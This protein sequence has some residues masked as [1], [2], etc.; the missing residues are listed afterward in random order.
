MATVEI[1]QSGRDAVRID[2]VRGAL[3]SS[4]S[5]QNRGDSDNGVFIIKTSADD[6][7]ARETVSE[8]MLKALS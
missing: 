3:D 2:E 1:D 7:S 6:H 5:V 8:N 4:Y